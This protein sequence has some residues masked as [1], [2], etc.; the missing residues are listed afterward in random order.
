V[1]V[2]VGWNMVF[3][4]LPTLISVVPVLWWIVWVGTGFVANVLG[5]SMGLM[6]IAIAWLRYRPL[7]WWAVLVLVLSTLW[8]LWWSNRKKQAKSHHTS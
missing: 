2:V 5:I 6:V 7:V 3:S 8:W 1:L 4:I